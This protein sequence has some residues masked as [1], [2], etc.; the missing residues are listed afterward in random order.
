[1]GVYCNNISGIA[2]VQVYS[3]SRREFL[4][5]KQLIRFKSFSKEEASF[6]QWT[7]NFDHTACPRHLPQ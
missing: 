7:L 3:F 1:M 6:V 5:P 2:G 4:Q